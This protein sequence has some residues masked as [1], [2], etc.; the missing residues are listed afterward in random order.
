[1][2]NNTFKQ[3]I[4]D[5]VSLDLQE[6]MTKMKDKIWLQN[7]KIKTLEV[8]LENQVQYSRRNCLLI[9]GVVK[10]M[11]KDTNETAIQIFKDYLVVNVTKSCIGTSHRLKSANEKSPIIVKFLSYNLRNLVFLNKKKLK[12]LG[13]KITEALT[14]QKRAC[15]KR[16]TE[17]RKKRL[18]HSNWTVDGK[19]FYT[20][21]DNTSAKLM[22]DHS[23]LDN[24][25]LKFAKQN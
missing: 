10:K 15:F 21:P 18:I 5:A 22:I 23:Y 11:N 17:L 3:I 9:R 12:D 14:L 25:D 8:S 2:S 1:M 20:K 13:I 19:I 6:K 4:C 24:I 16:L 7:E